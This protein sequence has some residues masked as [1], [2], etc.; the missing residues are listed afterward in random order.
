MLAERIPGP[1]TEMFADIAGDALIALPL[2]VSGPDGKTYSSCALIDESG[3]EY[4]TRKT[5]LYRDPQGFDTFDEAEVMSA[6]TDLQIF[7][8]DGAK[9][10]VLLGRD[11][12]FPENFQ[13]LASR[14]ANLILVPQNCIE[15]DLEFLRKM[16][17][18]HHV[19]LL[20]ANRLGFRAVY[21]S[22]PEQGAFAMPILLDKDCPAW[23]R[24]KGHSAIIGADGKF[25]RT[26]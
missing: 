12:T 18:Q 1:S 19:P 15:P 21:P 6:G 22:A 23:V 17:A 13:T 25:S 4:E 24:C 11:A 9:I 14:G 10:G 26:A 3:P 8:M 7:D 5:R 2:L 16:A 20:V